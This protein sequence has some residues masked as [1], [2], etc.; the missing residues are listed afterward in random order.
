[1][2]NKGFKQYLLQSEV[3]D[4][5]ATSAMLIE[6]AGKKVNIKEKH[7]ISC[8]Y[9]QQDKIDRLEKRLSALEKKEQI[10]LG[11]KE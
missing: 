2:M 7:F 10:D 4:V 6:L 1:M 3:K 5:S 9:E 11:F 8:L